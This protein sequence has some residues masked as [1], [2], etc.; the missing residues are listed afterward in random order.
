MNPVSSYFSDVCDPRG[1]SN[2]QRH[3]LIELLTIALCAMLS[4]AESFT[5]MEGFGQAKEPWIR[6]IQFSMS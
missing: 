4:G 2:A 5:D 6:V 3:Q 1:P